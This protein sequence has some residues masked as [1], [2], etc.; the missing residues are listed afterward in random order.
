MLSEDLFIEE[1]ARLG[2]ETEA[3]QKILAG[4]PE[5]SVGPAYSNGC[6]EWVGRLPDAYVRARPDV[7]R[8]GSNQAVFAGFRIGGREVRRTRYAPAVSDL[9]EADLSAVARSK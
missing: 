1:L 4:D 3:L 7:E 5:L 8:R 6:L 9:L 2:T